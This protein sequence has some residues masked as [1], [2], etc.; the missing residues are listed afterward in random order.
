MGNNG[1]AGLNIPVTLCRAVT[2]RR[3]QEEKKGLE[4]MEQ[5][6]KSAEATVRKQPNSHQQTR[7]MAEGNR[8]SH[9]ARRDLWFGGGLDMTHCPMLAL[10]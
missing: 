5:D 8:V 4:R 10:L 1:V 2:T 7:E 6:V 9:K 3:H